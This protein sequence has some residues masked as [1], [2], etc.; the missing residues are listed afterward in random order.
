MIDYIREFIDYHY[1]SIL[2]PS[3]TDVLKS[4]F[5]NHEERFEIFRNKHISLDDL[6]IRI[7]EYVINNIDIPLNIAIIKA[8]ENDK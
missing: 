2:L 6:L 8:I 3:L 4:Y 5:Y 7:E 1:K